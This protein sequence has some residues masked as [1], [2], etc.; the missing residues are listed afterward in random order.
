M[1]DNLD[2]IKV[3]QWIIGPK[4]CL[5]IRIYIA[6]CSLIQSSLHVS[7][8]VELWTFDVHIVYFHIAFSW[9]SL[10]FIFIY[11]LWPVEDGDA[12]DPCILATLRKLQDGYFAGARSVSI[13]LLLCRFLHGCCKITV[14]VPSFAHV[15]ILRGCYCRV[16]MSDLS[17][18][19][20]TSFH[21]RLSFLDEEND[22]S[23]LEDEEDGEEYGEEYNKCGPSGS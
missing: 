9:I 7:I 23:L 21:T 18:F 12:L 20:T 22:D 13:L 15:D 3:E 2:M 19:Q 6:I 16:Q 1:Q 11:F 14:Y 17:S 4:R 5:K 8:H 10:C